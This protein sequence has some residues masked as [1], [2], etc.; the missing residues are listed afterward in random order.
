MLY[1]Q[2]LQISKT[3]LYPPK[4]LLFSSNKVAYRKKTGTG[5]FKLQR[6]PWMKNAAYYVKRKKSYH[7]THPAQDTTNSRPYFNQE[8]EWYMR[9][10]R[11]VTHWKPSKSKN[12]E[13]KEQEES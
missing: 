9:K 5:N 1:A 6:G 12:K 10:K 3:L 7:F 13:K 2:S 8:K 4:T 11:G